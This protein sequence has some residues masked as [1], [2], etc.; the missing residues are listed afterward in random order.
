MEYGTQEANDAVEDFMKWFNHWMY[1]SSE[2]LGKEKGD[3]GLFN[4]DKWKEALFVKRVMEESVKLNQQFGNK[5]PMVKG[6]HARNVTCSSIAPTGTLSLMFRGFPMSYGIEPAFFMYYWKRTRMAGDYTYY[7]CVPRVVREM[8]KEAG[9]EIP[10]EADTIRDT[11]DGSKGR[12][13]AAFIEEHRSKFKFKEST[14]VDPMDKLQLMSQVMKWVDSSISVT[15]MLPIGSTWQDVYKFILA[16]HEKEVKSIA[17]F[18]DKKMY[19]IVSSMSFKE[20][21]F[22]LKSEGI[23]IDHQN[24]SDDELVELNISRETI[25]PILATIPK[26]LTTLDANIHILTVKGV[27][28]VIV[29]GVQNGQPYEIFGG[30]LNGLGIKSP[31][32]VGKL[33]KVK[34]GQYALEFDDIYIEDFSKQFTPTE[35]ILFRM[36]SMGLRHGVPRELIVEQLQKAT[37]DISSMAAAAARVL[38]K[39]IKNGTDLSG[40]SC[41]SCSSKLIYMEGCA[42][43]TNCGWSKCN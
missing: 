11:W 26:R 27:K 3:F 4:K 43:C 32:K 19:G 30:H 42:T 37:E 38:K 14:E 6:N 24:F 25:A 10:I 20:L 12:P 22:K 29:V 13:V 34:K 5:I 17:A 28:H 23:E 1:I 36:A 9:F 8:F 18:P 15:Y 21:A 33:H 35:Q 31:H 16:S 2:E 39:Y 40:Q 7:F 41:P